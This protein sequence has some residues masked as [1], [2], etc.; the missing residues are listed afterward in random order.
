MRLLCHPLIVFS[1]GGAHAQRS[2][3]MKHLGAH[4]LAAGGGGLA[5]ASRPTARLLILSSGNFAALSVARSLGAVHTQRSF[6]KS[7]AVK[8]HTP[9]SLSGCSSI[10]FHGCFP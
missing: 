8:E 2:R 7:S 3:S 10:V 1:G 6:P 9:D 4:P 5:A